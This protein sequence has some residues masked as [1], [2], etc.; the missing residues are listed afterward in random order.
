MII[1]RP[2]S[3][4]DGQI[5]Q[6]CNDFGA[7]VGTHVPKAL[8][9]LSQRMRAVAVV[10]T[11]LVPSGI[12]YRSHPTMTGVPLQ[13]DLATL[14][15]LGGTVSSVYMNTHSYGRASANDG[16]RFA[17]MT[18]DLEDRL[19][20]AGHDRKWVK[21][22]L[23]PLNDLAADDDFWQHQ[24]SSLAVFCT[25]T[26]FI[27]YVLSNPGIESVSL[28]TAANLLP[29]LQHVREIPPFLLLALSKNTVQLFE[30]DARSIVAIEDPNIPTSFDDAL[31][32]EDPEAQLQSR[33]QG[34]T[35]IIHGH[36]IGEEVNKERLERFLLAVDRAI[37]AR[38]VHPVRPLVLAAVDHYVARY[39]Q[40][41]SY[42]MLASGHIAG[43]PDRTTPE[44]L[45]TSATTILQTHDVAARAAEIERAHALIGTGKAET[46]NDVILDRARSGDIATLYINHSKDLFVDESSPHPRE[47]I[48]NEALIAT[49]TRSGIVVQAP[50]GTLNGVDALAVTRW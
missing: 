50:P 8:S 7:I 20:E 10:S 17:R 23:E 44:D 16:A 38:E 6:F 5:H 3:T 25:E 1:A 13:Q 12:M 18:K 14:A 9:Q 22:Y 45:F 34:G 47:S 40:L 33:S 30:C 28:A 21:H 35:H 24:Q 32:F 46:D 19:S 37:V 48:L 11:R 27:Y 15:A 29:L 2:Q 4:G 36:G 42:P 39:H 41:S 49:V 31:K 43:S 26:E